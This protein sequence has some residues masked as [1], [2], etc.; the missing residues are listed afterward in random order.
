MGVPPVPSSILMGCSL[1]N[2]IHLGIPPFITKKHID[3]FS[4]MYGLKFRVF[5]IVCSCTN[6]VKTM[7]FAIHLGM[8]NILPMMCGEIGKC[9]R[10][11]YYCVTTTIV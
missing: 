3:M 6:V 4:P 11:V 2:T 8:A 7:S 10:M 9:I 5:D 1:I